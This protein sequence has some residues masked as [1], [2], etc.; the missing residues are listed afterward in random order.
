M[1]TA[2]YNEYLAA[3][4]AL[5][6]QS[7]TMAAGLERA[8]NL[9]MEELDAAAR[10]VRETEEEAREVKERLR[11]LSD[12]LARLARELR[13]DLEPATD[14]RPPALA[15][16]Q[17]VARAITDLTRELDGIERNCEWVRRN[18]S[19]VESAA[20]SRQPVQPAA[21]EPVPLPANVTQ[22]AVPTKPAWQSPVLW[23]GVA[24]MLLIVLIVVVVLK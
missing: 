19:T 23:I 13:F 8:K 17:D 18:R 10:R 14:G 4:K 11:S 22:G 2:T 16:L 9:G 3:V 12:L 21:P 6:G 20:V 5:A 15:E 7:A 24:A 1:T